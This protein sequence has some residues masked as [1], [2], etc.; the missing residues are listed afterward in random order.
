MEKRFLLIAT[1][2]LFVGM[3]SAEGT[4]ETVP[5]G[6][7]AGSMTLFAAASTTDLVE[8]IGAL[9]EQETG[10]EVKISPASSGTL[11][12][13]IEQGAQADV[14]ISASVKWMAYV[15][16][17]SLAAEFTPFIKNRLVLIAPSEGATEDFSELD[18]DLDFPA[19]FK[20]RLSLGDPAHVPAG[21]YAVD[22]LT[23]FGWYESLESRF[24]P[25][26]D[27]R[28]ALAVVERGETERGIVYETDA[29]K[30]EKVT[31]VGRFPEDSHKAIEYYAALLRE[32]TPAGEKFYRFLTESE[33]VIPLYEKYGFTLTGVG[34]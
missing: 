25:G 9:F 27:V 32:S 29:A 8:E 13:Q 31:V 33:E 14:Y 15:D 24:L 22:G 26:A 6:K 34:K 7:A 21:Q 30:S 23:Y 4:A 1:A 2:I 11:A 3:L 28:A 17:L 18:P 20:G 19:S 10:I 12:R 5:P 16:D